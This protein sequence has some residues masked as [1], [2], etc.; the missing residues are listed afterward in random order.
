MKYLNT[1]YPSLFDGTNGNNISTNNTY[2]LIYMSIVSNPQSCIK[3]TS[4]TSLYIKFTWASA[5]ISTAFVAIL[6][7]KTSGSTYR[8]SENTTQLQLKNNSTN[9]VL[10]SDNVPSIANSPTNGLHS[11]DLFLHIDTT[12]DVIEVYSNSIKYCSV[13]GGLSGE[14]INEVDFGRLT[15]LPYYTA[16]LGQIIVSDTAFPVNETITE[17]SPTITSTDWTISSGVAST[18]SVGGSMTLTAPSGAVDETTR[19]VT[20]YGVAFL[21]STPSD[22]VNAINVTQGGNTKQVILPSGATETADTFTVTQ[23]SDISATA[24]SAYVPQ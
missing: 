10:W 17:I 9:T 15:S 24:V 14:T 12:L 11:R 13:S 23:L 21:G 4:S 8:L 22:T 16:Y 5:Y 20:G 1:K 19:T 18:D 7:I 6:D 3:N 2:N